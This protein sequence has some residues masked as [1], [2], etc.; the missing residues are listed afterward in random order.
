L[1][2]LDRRFFKFKL[3]LFMKTRTILLTLICL[4]STQR[5]LAT[6]FSETN[7]E[8]YL[9]ISGSST[10]EPVAFD[11]HLV[12]HPFC[13]T[14]AGEI[15]LNYPD[16]SYGIKVKM[17]DA[18]GKEIPRTKLGQDFGS[19]FDQVRSYED[20]IQTEH[21]GYH[22]GH[23]GSIMAQGTYD[24]ADGVS[25]PLLPAAKDLF[26]ID[27]PGVY[28]LEIQMQMFQI[29]KNTNQWTRK[30]IR[31]SPIKINVQKPP[32]P[33]ANSSLNARTNSTTK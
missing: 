21:G 1:A 27:D 14:N 13:N 32:E 22:S 8:I 6:D 30:L 7:N 15:E 10:N 31:F 18:S 4:S 20:L 26:Q 24:A 16:H 3:K 28:T 17:F 9:A 33:K 5:I 2:D 23:M 29:H 19:K 11:D 25:G 12:W